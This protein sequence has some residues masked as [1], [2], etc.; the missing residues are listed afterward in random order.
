MAE[1]KKAERQEAAALVV[2]CVMGSF[3]VSD[4]LAISQFLLFF[5]FMLGALTRMMTRLA[6]AGVGVATEGL[7]CCAPGDPQFHNSFILPCENQKGVFP[8]QSLYQPACIMN[9]VRQLGLN[10]F[11]RFDT[12]F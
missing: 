1:M 2:L 10:N 4:S 3:H 8:L 6:L 7:T 9:L 11:G 12:S 5:S